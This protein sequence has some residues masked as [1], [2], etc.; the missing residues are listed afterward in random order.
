[1][2]FHVGSIG[3]HY[4]SDLK[5]R[6][7]VRSPTSSESPRQELSCAQKQS[8]NPI[9]SKV[10]D[11]FVLIRIVRPFVIAVLELLAG[12]DGQSEPGRCSRSA[13]HKRFAQIFHLSAIHRSGIL[14]QA[15]P[16]FASRVR[17]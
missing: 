17:G 11:G 14:I 7:E 4:L 15:D 12:D 6:Y 8:S 3:G 9:F 13:F 10:I 16:T 2:H 5:R 1:M